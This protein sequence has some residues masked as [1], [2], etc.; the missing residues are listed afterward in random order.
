MAGHRNRTGQPGRSAHRHSTGVGH[1]RDLA[2]PPGFRLRCSDEFLQVRNAF[3][4]GK[5]SDDVRDGQVMPLAQ[6]KEFLTRHGQ[7]L[8]GGRLLAEWLGRWLF[9]DLVLEFGEFFLELAEVVFL[10]VHWGGSSTGGQIL[11][12]RPRAAECLRGIFDTMTFGTAFAWNCNDISLQF[13][14]LILE[15][16]LA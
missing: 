16:A 3:F 13:G 2:R 14:S 4:F 15:E 9:F 6:H 11:A 7:T 1:F 8:G 10:G 12:R 5:E